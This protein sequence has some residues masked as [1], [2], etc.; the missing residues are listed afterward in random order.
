M[1]GN[2]RMGH[3]SADGAYFCYLHL[4]LPIT[5]GGIPTGY[6]EINYKKP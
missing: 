1:E 3:G 2:S 5:G 6:F 4:E